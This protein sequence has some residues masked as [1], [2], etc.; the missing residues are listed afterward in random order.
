M[1]PNIEDISSEKVRGEI[2]YINKLRKWTSSAR[3]ITML[4]ASVTSFWLIYRVFVI[5]GFWAALVCFLGLSIV[6]GLGVSPMFV[7][8][9]NLLCFY[10]K[11]VG[12][13]LPIISYIL[14]IILLYVDMRVDNLRKRV[15]PYNLGS[16]NDR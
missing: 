2:R 1:T 7:V 6:Y 3:S 4:G 14:A 5:Y 12:I 13:W 8:A 16:I 15:D 10:F 11:V 9:T